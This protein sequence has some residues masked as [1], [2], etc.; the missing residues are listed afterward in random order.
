MKKH[1]S[2]VA[3][4]IVFSLLMSCTFSATAISSTEDILLA[5]E[6]ITSELK[7]QYVLTDGD[8]VL[9]QVWF[10]DIDMSVAEVFALKSTGITKDKLKSYETMDP[11]MTS[12]SSWEEQNDEIQAYIEAKREAA[13]DLYTEHNQRL[14][15]E[16]LSGAKVFYVSKYS[17]VVLVKLS[18][19]SAMALAEHSEVQMVSYHNSNDTRNVDSE[20]A[21]QVPISIS[22]INTITKVNSVHTSSNY[23]YTGR[24]VKVGVFDIGLPD[25]S[26]FSNLDI[27]KT[28]TNVNGIPAEKHASTVLEVVS[29]VA[30]NAEYYLA[31]SNTGVDDLAVI[32]E[33]LDCGVNV[34]TSSCSIGGGMSGC[35]YEQIEIWLDHIAYQHDVHFVQAAGNMGGGSTNGG[36][37]GPG[38][39]CMAYNIVVV[40]NINANGTLTYSDDVIDPKSS[41]YSGVNLANKPDICAPATGMI[42]KFYTAPTGGTSFA[43]PQVAGVIALLCEQR[44]ALKTQQTSV[45]AILTAGTNFASPH[46]YTPSNANYKIYGSGLLDCVGACYVAGNYR[47]LNSSIASGSTSK[48]HT[49]TVNSSDSRIRVSLAFNMR[50]IA[51]GDDHN[52]ITYLKLSDLDIQV[53]DPSGRVV[54]TSRTSN[55]NVEI[56][57]FVPTTT[58]KYSIVVTRV[59]KLSETVYYGLAWR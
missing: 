26:K 53:K 34:I 47:Y 30:P 16:L 13:R 15:D 17:P 28:I 36:V 20:R 46:C 54:G 38:P 5:D 1:K 41:Y 55:N 32:E 44:P 33:L 3:I 24:G 27:R 49:F 31:A 14:T 2:I 9:T 25:T 59:D 11:L 37:T 6:K 56:V 52:H 23:G 12:D 35:K 39:G 57:D 21:T 8:E 58:G 51:S 42:S 50:S 22:N 29:S 43:T 4:S 48:T 19:D 10:S 45:K 40:G 7:E 18:E